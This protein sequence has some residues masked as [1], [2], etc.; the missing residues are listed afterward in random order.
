MIVEDPWETNVR[1]YLSTQFT[2]FDD[3]S[4]GI[5]LILRQSEKI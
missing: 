2:I 5:L 1:C 4:C 3:S